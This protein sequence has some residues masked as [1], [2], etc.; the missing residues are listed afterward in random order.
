[1][2]LQLHNINRNTRSLVCV[3]AAD[4]A[5]ITHA[6]KT[7]PFFC[8]KANKYGVFTHKVHYYDR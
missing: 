1:M 4:T 6:H 5:V 3:Y 8:K 2:R 7:S